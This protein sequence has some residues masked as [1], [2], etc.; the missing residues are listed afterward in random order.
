MWREKQAKFLRNEIE[1]VLAYLPGDT[2]YRN[3]VREPLTRPRRGLAADCAQGIPWALLSLIVCEAISGRYEPALPVASALQFLTCAGDILDDVEYADRSDSLPVKYGRAVATNVATMH[4]MLAEKA[5]TRLKERGVKDHAII[6][7]MDAIN[8]FYINTCA[9]QHLGLSLD[10]GKY[11]PE[12][13]YLKITSL[14]SASQ[15]ECACHAGVLLA[16]ENRKLIRQFS[17]FGHK[18]GMATQITNDIKGIVTGSD[19]SRDKVSLPLVYALN[20]PRD[21]SCEQLRQIFQ[22]PERQIPDP[23]MIRDLLFRIGAM[24]Y[25]TVKME[26]YKQQATDI[27]YDVEKKKISVERLKFLLE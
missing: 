18:L 1:A 27:L 16:T 3:L 17:L 15:I 14:K 7:I 24:Q 6:H 26:A 23:A 5:I 13:L 4:I 25:A 9:G 21:E 22:K 20:Q 12:D 11:I 10:T 19:I 2:D 8:S